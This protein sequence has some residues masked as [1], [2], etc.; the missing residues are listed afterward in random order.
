MFDNRVIFSLLL[1]LVF[2]CIRKSLYSEHFQIGDFPLGISTVKITPYNKIVQM[3]YDLPPTLATEDC[4]SA[5]S[6]RQSGPNVLLGKS[7]F[8]DKPA[9]L[10]SSTDCVLSC[11]M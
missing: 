2:L 1:V 4:V 9:R 7:V 3:P 5:C 6:M 11:S 8:S 10:A